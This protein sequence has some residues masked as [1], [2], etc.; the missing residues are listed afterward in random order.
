[1]QGLASMRKHTTALA[2]GA[3]MTLAAPAVLAAPFGLIDTERFGYDGTVVRYD[4]EADARDGVNAVD[5]IQVSD[6]DLLLSIGNTPGVDIGVPDQNI[7]MGPWWH[8]TDEFYGPGQGRAGWGNT[9]GNTGVGFMQLFDGDSSTDTSVQMAFGNFD[10]T[11]YTEFTLS[12]EGENTTRAD[13]FSRFSAIDN[14]NDAGSYLDYALQ[15]TATGLEGTE[16][17]I[18][19]ENVVE[20]TNQP[21]G[22]TGSF[23]GLFHLTENQTS[24]ANQGF[25]TIDL[26]LDM[27]NWAYENRA[28]LTPQVSVDGGNTFFDGSFADSRFVA[29][30]VPEPGTL[31]LMAAGAGLFAGWR[32]SRR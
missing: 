18:D 11:H 12:L 26:T 2:L 32:R 6:R 23:T 7:I 20:A 29:R 13:D 8:T 21:T 28:D 16:V 14:V 5:T 19:G 10:G 15:L 17:V 27:D 25:Y 24:P 30:A 22:V 1:M 3:A 4:T 9:R 31:G